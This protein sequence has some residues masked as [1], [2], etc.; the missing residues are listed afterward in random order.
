M[1]FE[2]GNNLWKQ[3]HKSRAD[4]TDRLKAFFDVIVDGG[5]DT[6]G[7]KL[8]DLANSKEL[9]KE[10]LE[11]MD[12]FEGW[13]EFIVPKLSRTEQQTDITLTTEVGLVELAQ[14]LK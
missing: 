10:E 4:N 7:E 2:K 14:R 8:G 6:Y 11:F 3:S 12:R 5:I 1:P 9:T 13:R